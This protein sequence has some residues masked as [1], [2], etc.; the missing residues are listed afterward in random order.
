MLVYHLFF[1]IDFLQIFL[2]CKLYAIDIICLNVFFMFVCLSVYFHKK[3]NG[4][5][6][7]CVGWDI[8]FTLN[9]IPWATSG[10]SQSVGQSNDHET[11]FSVYSAR[12]AEVCVYFYFLS[13]K[14]HVFL[15]LNL[16]SHWKHTLQ[17][18]SHC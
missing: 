12:T 3:G 2:H 11:H 18:D 17:H 8:C 1:F 14:Q 13:V 6:P 7:V 5:Q 15:S 16:S 9:K 4:T 10:W